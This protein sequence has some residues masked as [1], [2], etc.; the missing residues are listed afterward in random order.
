MGRCGRATAPWYVVPAGRRWYRDRAVAH[1]L[2][3]DVRH[4]RSRVSACRFR[5]PAR[6]GAAAG[7]RGDAVDERQVND[8]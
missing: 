4:P 7:I 2:R 5:R 1:L 8:R 3:G 6:T